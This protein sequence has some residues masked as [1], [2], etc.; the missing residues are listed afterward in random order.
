MEG[1]TAPRCRTFTCRERALTNLS[2]DQGSLAHDGLISPRLRRRS[3]VHY[4]QTARQRQSRYEAVCTKQTKWHLST[5][6]SHGHF[7][8]LAAQRCEFNA[9]GFPQPVSA[10]DADSCRNYSLASLPPSWKES[11]GVAQ[12]TRGAGWWRWKPFLLQQRLREIGDGEVLV[13][14]DYDLL[15]G[16]DSSALYCLGQNA[17]HGVAAFHMP[18]FTE[19]AWTKRELADAL[20]ADDAMLDS[21]QAQA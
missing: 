14:V 16:Q 3:T 4:W 7:S 15:L 19:R 12:G 11:H 10:P 9:R 1:C 21:V 5:F 13:H 18:C 2:A 20:G 17:Q 6:G 8:Y